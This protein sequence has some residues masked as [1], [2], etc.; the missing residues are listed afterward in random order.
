MSKIQV[1]EYCGKEIPA[2][3]RKRKYCSES[4]AR[5]AEA[6]RLQKTSSGSYKRVEDSRA[7]MKKR[8]FIMAAYGGK[9]ALCG[10][11]MWKTPFFFRGKYYETNGLEIHHILPVKDGGSSE[12]N[13]LILLCPNC[14]KAAD[15]GL[16][17]EETLHGLQ[18]EEPIA[19]G[20]P[21]TYIS[22]AERK[23]YFKEAYKNLP[24]EEKS[25]TFFS[26]ILWESDY[27]GLATEVGNG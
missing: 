27:T 18:K 26:D 13:N 25:K 11:Q 9:C 22:P 1:C 14:H 20:G 15:A 5:K 10:W 16:I 2:G 7:V 12:W 4:C 8:D 23:R 17:S 6:D 24:D 21:I 19:I 3:S